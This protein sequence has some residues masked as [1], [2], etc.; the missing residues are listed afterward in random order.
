MH[1]IFHYYLHM[2][3]LTNLEIQAQKSS[4]HYFLVLSDEDDDRKLVLVWKEKSGTLT[5][6]HDVSAY[7]KT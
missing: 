1:S 5:M 2:V 7:Q 3:K 4:M 6:Y